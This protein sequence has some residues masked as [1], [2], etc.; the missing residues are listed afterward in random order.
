MHKITTLKCFSFRMY[1]NINGL[2]QER[3][4]S[5]ASAM[6]LCLSCTNPSIY[7]PGNLW[8]YM[9]HGTPYHRG[10]AWYDYTM[11]V[12]ICIGD[13]IY[14]QLSNTRVWPQEAM[15]LCSGVVNTAWGVQKVLIHVSIVIA[16]FLS[17]G[18]TIY[19]TWI[20]L[21]CVINKVTSFLH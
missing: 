3:R 7:T 13:L 5:S 12:M 2:V 20:Y 1:Y 11:C 17:V 16:F 10:M 9:K 19:N 14:T 18:P 4:N 6:E 15:V 21:Q 8:L